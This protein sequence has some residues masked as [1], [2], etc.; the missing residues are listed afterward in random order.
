MS[1][2]IQKT[3]GAESAPVETAQAETKPAVQA[4]RIKNTLESVERDLFAQQN[5]SDK[6]PAFEPGDT[7]KVHVK[8][9]E[10][11][12]TRIQPFEGTVLAIKHGGNRKTFMVRRVSFGVAIERVF[13]IHTPFI[14][15]I[16]VIRKGRVRRAKL[17]Y[18]RGRFGR[19]A[20]VTEKV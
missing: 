4:V 10:G 14:E 20:V 8:I 13:P 15:K 19:S 6:F 11:D 5:N 17:Y 18:M 9:I 2:E 1:E 7:V 16:E 3:D 12:K